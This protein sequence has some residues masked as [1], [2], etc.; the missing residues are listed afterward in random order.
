MAAPGE[1]VT[2]QFT[3]RNPTTK[4]RSNADALPTAVLVRN[5]EDTAIVCTVLNVTT[6]VYKVT[7]SIPATYVTGDEIEFRI[8]ATV[9]SVTDNYVI[10]LGEVET[11]ATIAPTATST[12]WITNLTNTRAAFSQTLLEISASPKPTYSVDGQSVSWESYTR[13][14]LDQIKAID[15]LL[16][17]QEEPFEEISMGFF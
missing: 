11:R 3:T 7:C 10:D 13:M 15:D 12:D 5:G 4:V 6:G 8:T 14:L 9:A 17:T 1:V 16:Q 2:K